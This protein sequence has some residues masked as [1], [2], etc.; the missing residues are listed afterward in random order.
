MSDLSVIA[1]L[2]PM[3]TRVGGLPAEDHLPRVQRTFPTGLPSHWYGWR[4][5]QSG[6]PRSGRVTCQKVEWSRLDTE[7]S[8]P[9][10]SEWHATPTPVASAY[11]KYLY[12]GKEKINKDAIFRVTCIP[13]LPSS[14]RDATEWASLLRN[15]AIDLSR[16]TRV[17]FHSVPFNPSHHLLKEPPPQKWLRPTITLLLETA[18]VMVAQ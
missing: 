9:S 13:S 8:R 5:E 18:F 4:V 2:N 3:S 12:R 11:P 7:V 15:L 10:C 14:V 16:L 17:P 1:V 6:C